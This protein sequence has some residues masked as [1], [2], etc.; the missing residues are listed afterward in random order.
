MNLTLDLPQEL[1]RELLLEADRL[2]LPVEEYAV[3]LLAEKALGSEKPRT[4]FEVVEY[5]RRADLIGYRSDLPDSAAHA[6]RVRRKAE[7]RAR[8]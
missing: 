6:R 3:R 1:E 7:R 5:W 4:G 8:G 2:G